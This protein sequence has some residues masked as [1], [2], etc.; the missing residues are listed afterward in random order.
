MWKIPDELLIENGGNIVK[1][2]NS[3]GSV[4][5]RPVNVKA[6]VGSYTGAGMPDMS[7][8]KARAGQKIED[9]GFELE[10]DAN[11]YCVSARNLNWIT[12]EDPETDGG[13]WKA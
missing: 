12:P 10:Y 1:I 2:E 13:H 8:N 11:G 3:D 4:T 9:K 7:R 6:G 5:Y